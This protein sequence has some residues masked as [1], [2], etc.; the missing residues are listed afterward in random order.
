MANRRERG[1]RIVRRNRWQLARGLWPLVLVLPAITSFL[2]GDPMGILFLMNAAVLTV[3]MV[4]SR[5]ELN[6]NARMIP[7]TLRIDDETLRLGDRVFDR[8]RIQG[9][10]SLAEGGPRL[11]LHIAGE[12]LPVE[13]ELGSGREVMAVLRELGVAPEQAVAVFG[14]VA[15]PPASVFGGLLWVVLL[16]PL[17]AL[18]FYLKTIWMWL[19]FATACLLIGVLLLTWR[20]R[21]SVGADGIEI[22]RGI[23]GKRFVR[24]DE[25]AAVETDLPGGRCVVSLRLVNGDRERIAFRDPSRSR[26]F[27]AR[28]ERN[29]AAAAETPAADVAQALCRGVGR[30]VKDWVARLRVLLDLATPRGAALTVSQ[31]WHV[32]EHPGASPIERAA[33]AVAV[34]RHCD[35]PTRERLARV[36]AATA[37]PRLRIVLDA[38]RGG[39]DDNAIAEALAELEAAEAGATNGPNASARARS[40]GWE[41][42]GG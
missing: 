2:R 25:I 39:A 5:W 3:G 41:D 7:A 18:A 20:R 40:G 36:A 23:R 35:R 30:D 29:R 8:H 16:A 12:I 4:R 9:G 27:R 21:V 37:S 14:A 38:V 15:A 19:A 32:I 13:L 33:A 6:K 31:L 26:A 24:H 28:V 42:V 1:V 11:R 17:A 34:G 10:Y 22:E